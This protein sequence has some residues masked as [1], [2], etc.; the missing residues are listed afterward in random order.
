VPSCGVA[1]AG[2]GGGGRQ[3]VRSCFGG[4]DSKQRH[5]GV[6]ERQGQIAF[7]DWLHTW[8]RI[9]ESDERRR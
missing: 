9:L 6:K 1:A 5:A 2:G 3:G 7:E 4:A 8:H